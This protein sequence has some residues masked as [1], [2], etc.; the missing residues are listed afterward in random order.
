M[1]D[2]FEYWDEIP[3]H[4]LK[5]LESFPEDEWTYQL[6]DELIKKL[7]AIGYTCEYGPDAEPF[8]LHKIKTMSKIH[9]GYRSPKRYYDRIECNETLESTEEFRLQAHLNLV[10]ITAPQFIADIVRKNLFCRADEG[11]EEMNI[12]H[13]GDN[14]LMESLPH[15][16]EV[17]SGDDYRMYLRFAKWVEDNNIDWI[18][19]YNPVE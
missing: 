9:H 1:K 16:D 8:N 6:Y 7:N 4:V 3:E 18:C 5:V 12:Y 2:L 14:N 10:Y 19:F 13:V 17:L 15:F 11:D